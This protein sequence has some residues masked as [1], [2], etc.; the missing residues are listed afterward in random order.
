MN[1][2]RELDLSSC[3]LRDFDSMF[4]YTNCPNLKELNLSHNMMATLRGLG[5]LPTLKVLRLKSNRIET[6]FC[7][8]SP[9][10]KSLKR[11][12][13]GLPALEVLDVSFNRL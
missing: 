8:P 3:K 1:D 13:F 7:K 5:Y 2:I 10:E 12:L 4:D 11:G 9:E 6:L